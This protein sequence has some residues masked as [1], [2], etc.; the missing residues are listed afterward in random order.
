[1]VHM[2]AVRVIRSIGDFDFGFGLDYELTLGRTQYLLY[3][4]G[5]SALSWVVGVRWAS[6]AMIGFYLAGTVL[7]TR[8]LL[9]ALGK[10]ERAAVFVVPFLFNCS[11]EIGF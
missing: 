8:S 2:A 5:S 11:L 1:P 6:F 3:Y 4:L 9:L 7:A 10:D